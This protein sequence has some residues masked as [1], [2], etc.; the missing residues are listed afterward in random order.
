MKHKPLLTVITLALTGIAMA[1]PKI[2]PARI[3]SMVHQVLRQASLPADAPQAAELRQQAEM[4]LQA[5]D[6][7]KAEALKI[8]LD[9]QADVQIQ[10]KN[11]EA[12]F[13]AAQYADY[14][15]KNVKIDEA[16]L[17]LKYENLTRM[18]RIQQ[19]RFP[20]LEEAKQAQQLLLKGLSFEEL[21]KR[22]PNPD[23]QNMPDL[24][25][26]QQLP[27]EIA[28]AA[29][30]MVRGEVNRE[31][32]LYNGEYYLL[33]IAASERSPEA[34]AFEQA[35]DKLIQQAKQEKT[36]EQINQLLKTH[37]IQLP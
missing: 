16:E 34:P 35:K 29:N 6:V 1:T 14:L 7:L 12:Q 26:I 4:Q 20:T 17:R 30:Q 8:G 19:V 10:F 11:M 3:D 18:V 15:E 9:R 5:M 13:Y 31:P 21:V 37:G 27:T 2:E 32:V 23:Q 24:I 33:K 28:Q 22:Y 25:T 36:Q